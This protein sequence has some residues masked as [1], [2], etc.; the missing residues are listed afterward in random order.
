MASPIQKILQEASFAYMNKAGVVVRLAIS[1]IVEDHMDTEEAINKSLQE[2]QMDLFWESAVEAAIAKAFAKGAGIATIPL[3]PELREA[4]DPSGMKLSEKLHGTQKEMRQ[5]IISTIQQQQKLGKHAMQAARALYDGYNSGVHV[6]RKQELP[7]YMQDIVNFVRRSEFP[8]DDYYA[9][10]RLVRRAQR[11]TERLGS[12]GAPNRALRTAYERLLQAIEDNNTKAIENAVKTAVEEKSRYVAER[13]A[14]TEAARAWADGFHSKY[15]GDTEVVAYRWQLSSRHP[16]YDICDMYAHANLWG[17][18]PGIFPKDKTPTLPVHPHCLCHLSLVYVTELDGKKEKDNIKAGG[19]RYLKQ[20]SHLKRCQLMGIEGAKDWE[21]GYAQWMDKVRNYEIKAFH[22]R[23]KQTGVFNGAYNDKN[24]PYGEKRDL[25]AKRFYQT[26]RNSNK[27]SVISK[28]A[29]H[30]HFSV[31]SVEKI[32][33][34]VFVDEHSF[35]DGTRHK[36]YPDYYMAQSFQR[37]YTGQEVRKYDII[38]LK[39]ERLEYEL[40]NR[41]GIKIYEEAHALAEKKY[42]YSAIIKKILDEGKSHD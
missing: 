41:Y 1:Y 9:L 15:D 7:K 33:R 42:N 26:L 16:H 34:H 38:M 11:Q 12:H 13:I 37:L 4:W 14:R 32:Y 23:I 36:F 25:H 35:S 40:M 21:H 22:S 24:D 39:H 17:L 31:G 5:A 3:L 27:E 18:G 28:I 10:M 29:T 20:Q 30:S 19:D 6:I 8:D 2:S